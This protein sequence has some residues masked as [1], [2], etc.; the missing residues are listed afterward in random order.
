MSFTQINQG[1]ENG[2]SFIDQGVGPPGQSWL[3]GAPFFNGVSD[4]FGTP[5]GATG[6]FGTSARLENIILRIERTGGGMSSV[7]MNIYEG[8]PVDGEDVNDS[9]S[10][11]SP[12]TVDFNDD[13][14]G[15]EDAVFDFSSQSINLT[16]GTTYF[17]WLSVVEST[18]GNHS[19]QRTAT[20]GVDMSGDVYSDGVFFRADTGGIIV[21]SGTAFADMTFR[22]NMSEISTGV[23]DP[24]ITCLNGEKYEM[25]V[26]NNCYCMLDTMDPED[27]LIINSK[28]HVRKSGKSYFRYI[29][30][31]YAGEEVIVRLP[32][33][34]LMKIEDGDFVLG[35]SQR[36][37]SSNIEEVVC[38]D[39]I[40]E[41]IVHTKK[42]GDVTVYIAKNKYKFGLKGNL[43][44]FNTEMSVGSL[45]SENDLMVIPSL[46]HQN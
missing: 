25:P 5:L 21:I 35:N 20:F 7:T 12:V 36:Y 14:V 1:V 23:G 17:F 44:R 4:A 33:L 28:L 30:I 27:R 8:T 41:Y 24:K 9:V 31:W 32:N 3:A 18:R 13:T 42:Y 26:D 45:K 10:I 29:Y 16:S 46:D 43:S 11:G 15:Y 37:S 22:V 40:R 2:D 34:R 19:F 6:T 38:S 39:R